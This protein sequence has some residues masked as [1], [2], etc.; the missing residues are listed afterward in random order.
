MCRLPAPSSSRYLSHQILIIQGTAHRCAEG[1]WSSITAQSESGRRLRIR[2]AG[3]AVSRRATP[4]CGGA[5][6]AH[7]R[8]LRLDLHVQAWA[9]RRPHCLHVQ[10]MCMALDPC[11]SR[12]CLAGIFLAGSGVGVAG[13]HAR[14]HRN[15]VS[16]ARR[17]QP[18]CIP[19]P[20]PPVSTPDA[21]LGQPCSRAPTCVCCRDLGGGKEGGRGVKGRGREGGGLGGRRGL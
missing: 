20:P 18:P 16:V 7:L 2:S 19:R 5:V 6:A 4:A 15:E 11:M 13:A 8:P 9:E 3:I 17:R 21:L 14:L 10:S 1:G 12:A